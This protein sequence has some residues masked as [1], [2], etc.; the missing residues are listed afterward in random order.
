ML[1]HLVRMTLLEPDCRLRA[2]E[3]WLDSTLDVNSAAVILRASMLLH[4]TFGRTLREQLLL[5][6]SLI[7][8]SCLSYYVLLTARVW[9]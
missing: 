8:T 1:L 7:N 3:A 4:T 2:F 6:L 5:I 9:T